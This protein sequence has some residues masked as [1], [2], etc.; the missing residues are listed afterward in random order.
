MKKLWAVIL[1]FLVL[2]GWSRWGAKE[3]AP[4]TSSEIELLST[5]L[6]AAGVQPLGGELHAWAKSRGESSLLELEAAVEAIVREFGL[7]RQEYDINSRSSGQ[8]AYAQMEG[9]LGSGMLRVTATSLGPETTIEVDLYQCQVEDLAAKAYN[10]KKAFASLG[11]AGKDVKI[12]TCLEGTLNARLKNSDKLNLVY[13]VFNSINATY[14]GAVEAKGISQWSG[15]TPLIPDAVDAGGK[16]V[17]FGLSLR[18]DADAS[19]HILRVA[20]PVL[21][22]SY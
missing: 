11:E 1:V 18:W 5:A 13:V 17:N 19:K 10:L 6:S 12:T 8:Y 15:W 20:T 21:P 3:E 2:T 16:Q 7:K 14:R 22:S 9:D 4:A